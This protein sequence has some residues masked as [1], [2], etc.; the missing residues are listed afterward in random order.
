MNFETY[1]LGV[2]SNFRGQ[3]LVEQLS[4]LG[5]TPKVIWGPEVNIDKELIL[6]LTNQE[7]A[8]FTIRRDIK[9]QEV[10]CCEG[11]IRMYREFL[12]SKKEW[13]LFFE[14]DA[15]LL[16]NP[17]PLLSKLVT[18]SEPVQLFIH[19]GPGTDLTIPFNRSQ[20]KY[21]T[22]FEKKLDPQYGAYGYILNKSAVVAILDSKITTYIN[23]P[24]WPYLWPKEITFFHSK[25]PYVNHPQDNSLSIIGERLNDS[26]RVINLLPNPCRVLRGMLLGLNLSE[27]LD[28][29]I[30]RKLYRTLLLTTRKA[31]LKK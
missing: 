17:L 18:S 21:K 29:E 2:Q 14:D 12:F 27:L 20:K 11:H 9:P 28:R 30:S 1:I 24:D 26:A 3:P 19:D 5:I 10:A 16:E 22:N 13:G 7:Y 25:K 15:I 23:T 8:N 6:N 31:K 4:C